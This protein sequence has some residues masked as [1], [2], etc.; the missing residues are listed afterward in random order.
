M[1]KLWIPFGYA[2][3]PTDR[4]HASVGRLY[5]TEGVKFFKT[6]IIFESLGPDFS[7]F[8]MFCLLVLSNN[9]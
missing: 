5:G 9:Q 3:S 1:T 4:W 6:Q 7:L 8:L 2:V